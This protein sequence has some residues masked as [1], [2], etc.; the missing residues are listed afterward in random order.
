MDYNIG[1][2]ETD[3][4]SIEAYGKRL[5]GKTFLDVCNEDDINN[6]AGGLNLS[7][8]TIIDPKTSNLT[9]EL[10]SVPKATAAKLALTATA[11]PP[12][13]P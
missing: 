3:P 12:L 8:A 1:Y 13:L 10:V 9:E 7:D 11:E 2:D 5:V 6:N 4:L